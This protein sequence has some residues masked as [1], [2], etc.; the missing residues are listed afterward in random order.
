MP[1]DV[2]EDHRHVLARETGMTEGDVAEAHRHIRWQV[3]IDETLSAWANLLALM[4]PI[5][6]RY[7]LELERRPIVFAQYW[8]FEYSVHPVL[9]QTNRIS[10]TVRPMQR[11]FLLRI[12]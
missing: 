5:L 12:A 9:T 4:T 10:G 6:D 3:R 11:V 7:Y 2:T 8:M 1:E